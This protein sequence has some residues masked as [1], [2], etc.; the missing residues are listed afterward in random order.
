MPNVDIPQGIDTGGKP[1]LEENIKLMDTLPTPHDS[2]L[3]GGYTPGSDEGRKTLAELMKTCTILSNKV[4]QSETELSTTKAIY[5]KAFITLTNKVKRIWDHAHTFIPKDSEIERD[6]IKRAGFDLQ[7]GSSKKQR[8]DQQTKETEEEA[9]AQG[10]SDQEVKELKIYMR[11]IPE[12]NIE[13]KAIPLA[14]KPLVIIKYKIVKEKS[15]LI[16]L[17]ELMEALEDTP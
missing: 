16:T 11:I 4:T 10:D 7:Q 14:I 9:T 17:Q 3:T 13:I 5:N 8:L 12:E 1:R 6:V 15:A 2:P